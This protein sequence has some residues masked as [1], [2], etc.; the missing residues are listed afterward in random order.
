MS[1]VFVCVGLTYGDEGKGTTVDYLVRKHSAKLVVRFNGG[2]Q[3]AHFVVRPDKVCPQISDIRC[4]WGCALAF[5]TRPT[6]TVQHHQQSCTGA[7]T[8]PPFPNPLIGRG[9][10][11]IS[12]TPQA[13]PQ[14][15]NHG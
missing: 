13:H 7:C 4:S 2:P 8:H 6:T 14:P 5:I 12:T 10:V 1:K 15:R 9:V 11:E 3:A